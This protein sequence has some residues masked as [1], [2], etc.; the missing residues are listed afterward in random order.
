MNRYQHILPLT[1]DL[2]A[3][4][5]FSHL[6]D[7]EISSLH[8]LIMKMKEPLSPLQAS[9]LLTFWNHADAVQIPASLLYRCNTV[10]QQLGRNPIEELLPE[11]D[12]Y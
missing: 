12:T 2:L 3:G 9:L 7:E 5:A 4:G 1:I 10:L 11:M 6:K 8:R